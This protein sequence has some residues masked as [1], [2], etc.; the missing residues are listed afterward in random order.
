M[1]PSKAGGGVHPKYSENNVLSKTKYDLPATL[2]RYVSTITSS[3]R[4]WQVLIVNL[5]AGRQ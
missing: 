3:A 2:E 4:I 5:F 1:S